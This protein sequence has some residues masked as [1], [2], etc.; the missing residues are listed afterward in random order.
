MKPAYF[1]CLLI[2]ILFISSCKKEN[3]VVIYEAG[4]Q[5]YGWAK[6][7]K[8]GY[9]WEA[10]GYWRYH[11]NDSTHW[12]IDFVTYSSYG[13][14]RENITLNE[15]PYSTGTYPVRGRIRDL[16]DGFVGG[17]F[18][19]RADDGDALIGYLEPNNDENGYITVSEI[20]TM[21]NTMKGFFEIYFISVDGS[22]KIE[23]KDGEY[24]VGLYG[25]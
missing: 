21:T 7:T 20:D 18:G 16:G 13:A 5:E 3:M 23:I 9:D 11:R 12:G 22:L 1:S 19:M 8:E 2:G 14:E 4:D 17:S 24:E 6:G 15:I 25:E 10:S